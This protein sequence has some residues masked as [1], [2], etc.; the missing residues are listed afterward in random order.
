METTHL[1][2]FGFVLCLEACRRFSVL[3]ESRTFFVMW[4]GFPSCRPFPELSVPSPLKPQ[5]FLEDE[6][7]D[8]SLP[9]SSWLPPFCFLCLFA[10]MPETS[11]S[12]SLMYSFFHQCLLCYFASIIFSN[13]Y[14]HT[15]VIS[16]SLFLVSCLF[17]FFQSKLFLLCWH[18]CL[19]FLP[20]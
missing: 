6:D 19:W 10:Q 8:T 7:R 20:R 15:L 18:R 11:R 5:G 17:L 4:L 9:V 16:K 1:A 2:L 3:R 14:F 12:Q 13:V